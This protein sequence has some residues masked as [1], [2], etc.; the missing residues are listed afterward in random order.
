MP[1]KN[2]LNVWRPEQKQV[3]KKVSLFLPVLFS[4]SRESCTVTG[5]AVFVTCAVLKR[6]PLFNLLAAGQCTKLTKL[7]RL[8]TTFHSGDIALGAALYAKGVHSLLSSV[9]T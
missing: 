7:Q 5:P 8:E 2:E 4:F 6:K 9:A 1:R 3:G